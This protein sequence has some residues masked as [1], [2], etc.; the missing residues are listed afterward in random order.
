MQVRE[1]ALTRWG[2]YLDHLAGHFGFEVS[3]YFLRF[4]LADSPR[5]MIY[6]MAMWYSRD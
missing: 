3:L 4:A 5:Y 6:Y 1:D 2:G